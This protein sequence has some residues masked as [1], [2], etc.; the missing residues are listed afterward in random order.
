MERIRNDI[1]IN[2]E[3][4][5]ADLANGTI[6][7]KRANEIINE[8]AKRNVESKP[9]TKF[10]LTE[11]QEKSRILSQITTAIRE[12]TDKYHI[13]N[14]EE[15]VLQ[16]KELCQGDISRA[17]STVVENLI[18]EKDFETARRV[19]DKF[20]IKNEDKQIE[21]YII[22]LKNKI[23]NAE[24]SDF[25]LRGLNMNS[26][27]D[28]E[29]AYFELIEKGLKR[30]NVKL[31]AISLGKSQDGLRNISLADIWPGESQQEKIR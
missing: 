6:D 28:E 7:I 4:I 13:K 12:K 18:N 3:L 22:S 8:E 30:K 24:I 2:I 5:I 23:K 1:P 19:C 27:E 31:G 17:V 9:K 16:V 11:E 29:K 10:A 21:K 14:P 15:T 25:V 26:T 20:S